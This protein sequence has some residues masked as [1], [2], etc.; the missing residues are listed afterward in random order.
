M[1]KHS[2]ATADKAHRPV[3]FPGIVPGS[4]CKRGSHLSRPGGDSG[5]ALRRPAKV[6]RYGCGD[7]CDPGHPAGDV[8]VPMEKSLRGITVGCVRAS[9]ACG[10][11]V[12]RMRFRSVQHRIE[13]RV[14]PGLQLTEEVRDLRVLHRLAGFVDEEILLGDVR[15]VRR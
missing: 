3:D 4:S 8:A 10:G 2:C 5:A 11:R 1:C 9:A 7:G 13:N 14:L 15:D 6:L 12:S